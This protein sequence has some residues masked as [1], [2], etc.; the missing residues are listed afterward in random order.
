MNSINIYSKKNKD[1]ITIRP[2]GGV[3]QIGSNMF[4]IYN[5][6]LDILIDAGILF[7]SDDCFNIKCL[8]PDM[9]VLETIPTDILITHGHEDHIGAITFVVKKFPNIKIHAPAFAAELIKSKFKH[10]NI[11]HYINIYDEKTIF[12]FDSF[13]VHPI[14]V[15]HSIPHTFGLLFKEKNNLLSI[16]YVSDFK[17]NSDDLYNNNFNFKRLKKLNKNIDKRI[18]FADSTNIFVDKI[19]TAEKDVI[20]GLT[21]E[22][23]GTNRK[24]ITLFSSNIFRMQ[25]IINIAIKLNKKI[26]PYGRAVFSYL[27]I[28]SNLNIIK[29]LDKVIQT[30]T[31]IDNNTENIIILLSGCQGDFKGTLRRVITLND[32]LFLPRSSDHFI[33]SSKIIPGNEK[34]IAYLYNKLSSIGCKITTAN[35]A[36]IHTSGHAS[37]SDLKQFYSEFNPSDVI[38]IH[39]ETSFLREHLRII[40]RHFPTT[41]GHFLENHDVLSIETDLKISILKVDKEIAPIIIQGKSIPT[42]KEVISERRKLAENGAIFVAVNRSTNDLQYKI[43]GVPSE[44]CNNF[45]SFVKTFIRKGLSEEDLRIAIRRYFLNLLGYR[46]ITV[47]IYL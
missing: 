11:A 32:S 37:K 35:E 7:P 1:L 10:E 19:T 46:P 36:L 45:E 25:S 22:L 31:Q 27:E 6:G 29:G 44:Y 8:I 16:F 42:P 34:K 2:L 26:V 14:S 3:G 43:L 20:D 13:E 39:G 4:H 47:C 18:V 41:K 24:F 5:D 15:N 12:N 21:V 30:S 23:S 9:S 17:I 33:F 28:A 40:D 38:P